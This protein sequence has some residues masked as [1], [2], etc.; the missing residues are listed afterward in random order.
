MK[1]KARLHRSEIF[2]LCFQVNCNWNARF[3][4]S[5][6]GTKLFEEEEF[7]AASRILLAHIVR[8]TIF[9]LK[10]WYRKSINDI[11]FFSN[12]DE[13]VSIQEKMITYNSIS[14]P[15]RKRSRKSVHFWVWQKEAIFLFPTIHLCDV[16]SC[17]I[18]QTVVL[19]I[20]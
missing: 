9:G 1:K 5:N 14:I 3:H 2:S 16:I 4:S 19:I 15:Y 18:E 6:L 13:M 10:S 7:C 12:L 20:L 11:S 8:E 17:I